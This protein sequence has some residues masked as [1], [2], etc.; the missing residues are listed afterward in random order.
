LVYDFISRKNVRNEMISLKVNPD[1]ALK[2]IDSLSD[3]EVQLI[4]G[5][6]STMPAGEGAVGP[7]VGGAG[8]DL[9]YIAYR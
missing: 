9:H 3:S 7:I 1:E 2:R 6:I 5:Q 8:G 4:A